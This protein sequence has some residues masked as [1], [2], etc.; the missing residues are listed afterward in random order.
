[1]AR[2]KGIF[3]ADD[4]VAAPCGVMSVA[5]I[6]EHTNSVEDERWINGY[7]Q[8]VISDPTVRVLTAATATVPGSLIH[9][10]YGDP[11]YFDVKPFFIEVEHKAS[12]LSLLGNDPREIVKKQIEAVTQKAVEYE[13]WEGVTAQAAGNTNNFFRRDPADNGP[14]VLTSGGVA[15]KKALALLEGAIGKSATGGGGVIHM[16]REVASSI[17]G[18]GVGYSTDDH[19][20]GFLLTSLGTPVSVGSG[21]T[22]NGPLNT[23]GSAVTATNHWIYVTGPIVVHLGPAE[24]VNDGLAQGFEF[25][26]NDSIVKSLRPAA[27]Q[28]DTTIFYAAQVT[29]PDVP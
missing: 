22:G 4:L 12:G 16:T 6:I 15:P 21:Y 2:F 14:Q 18:G 11:R 28:F 3:P 10:G 17:V 20:E 8:D 29:L 19:G 9:D 25:R 24:P 23:T 7:S 5:T 1:M 26:T 27:V 13:L